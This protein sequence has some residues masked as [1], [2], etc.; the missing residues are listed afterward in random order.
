MIPLVASFMALIGLPG[1]VLLRYALHVAKVRSIFGFALAGAVD[2][3]AILSLFSMFKGVRTPDD[4]YVMVSLCVAGAVAGT[5][6]RFVELKV[7][8]KK[9]FSA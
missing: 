1:F 3:A 8:P 9:E 6:Y 2:A 5:V 7:V 4:Q